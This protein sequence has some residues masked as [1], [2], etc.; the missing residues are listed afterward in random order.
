MSTIAFKPSVA[1][2]SVARER[3][4]IEQVNYSDL[5][6]KLLK[7]CVFGFQA[8][9]LATCIQSVPAPI[10]PTISPVGTVSL[11]NSTEILPEPF[12]LD[13]GVRVFENTLEEESTPGYGGLEFATIR[14]NEIQYL[15]YVLRNTL[16]SA[17]QWG[18]VRVLP[19][20]DPSMDLLL[21]GAVLRSNGQELQIHIKVHDSAGR[22]WLNKKYTDVT[23]DEDFPESTRYT[24]G[25]RFDPTSFT[26]PFQDLYNKINNDLVAARARLSEQEILN[27]GLV[28]Q[29]VYAADL[30]P[31]S[32]GHTLY[33]NPSGQ[34]SLVSLP[35]KD[36][37]MMARVQDMRVRHYLF[38][39][40]VD[41]YYQA[42]YED[43]QPSYVIWRRYSYDQITQNEAASQEAYDISRYSSST[44]YLTLIQRYDRFR[45]SK[46]YEVEFRELASGFNREIAPAI[47]ELNKQVHGLSGTMEEQYIQWRRILRQLFTLESSPL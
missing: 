17:N 29:M 26:D 16:I 3:H 1:G 28:S 6:I 19:Q 24:P 18:A 21:S 34:I 40:T 9:A 42:L 39:D 41:E 36:D 10:E 38:I 31:S 8:L 4:W 46:I 14:E 2:E 12:L 25:N 47:L 33:T 27:I 35:A 32:F 22:E 23:I 5:I 30:S 7:S 15:P 13:I 44:G 43:M 20:D 45:W 11:D 37:P